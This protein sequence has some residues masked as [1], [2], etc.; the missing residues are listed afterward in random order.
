MVAPRINLKKSTSKLVIIFSSVVFSSLLALTPLIQNIEENFGLSLLFHM[1]GEISAPEDTI[2]IAMDRASAKDLQIPDQRGIWPRQYHT[3][4]TQQLNEAGA[5]VIVFDILFK[6]KYSKTIDYNFAQAI[7]TADNVVLFE[8]LDREIAD[9]QASNIII[10]KQ[11]RPIKILDQSAAA[12]AAFPLPKVP[13]K[14]SQYWK[15]TPSTGGSPSLPSSALLI[16]LIDYLPTF[17]EQQ[18]HL[19]IATN[20]KISFSTKDIQK[21]LTGKPT[22]PFAI[23]NNSQEISA[24]NSLYNSKNSEYLNFYG[25]AQTIKTISYSKV[26]RMSPEQ[27]HRIFHNKAVFI[28]A[29]N[30]QQ[31]N[32]HDSFHTIFTDEDGLDISGVE[33]AATAFSNL[34][35]SKP[36]TPLT[37]TNTLSVIALWGAVISLLCISLPALFSLL[38]IIFLSTIYLSLSITI[39]TSYNLW[40]PIIMPLLIQTILIF[41]TSITYRNVLAGKER[42]KIIKT[43]TRFIPEQEIEQL[44]KTTTSQHNKGKIV[45]GI[46]LFTDIEQYTS[47]SETLSPNELSQLINQY[48][49]KVFAIIQ[50]YDGFISDAKGDS[51]LAIWSA[52]K[53]NIK[54]YSSACHAALDISSAINKFNTHNFKSPLPTRIGL[55][56]GEFHLG[57]SGTNEHYE[58]RTTGDCINTCARVTGMNK[59]LGTKILITEELLAHVDDVT[60][61]PLGRFKL[62]GKEKNINLA[63][64][65]SKK[66]HHQSKNILTLESFSKGLDFFTNQQW[67]EA[68]KQFSSS[69]NHDLAANFYIQ[70]CEQLQQTNLPEDWDGSITMNEK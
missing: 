34:L 57:I 54:A 35:E 20:D 12:T 23:K 70:H 43:F 3:R 67:N 4:L 26:L 18:S 22:N 64:L 52:D 2:I 21:E 8:Y 17:I 38:S 59:H 33:I 42:K 14:V 10:N 39:F 27:R 1:R 16:Y 5:K 28:G 65:I 61:R 53:N 31:W 44:L 13:F 11:I 29:S 36:I 50:Q 15:F 58:Y 63:E 32:Q 19:S 40:P 56:C 9:S 41:L 45:S 48:H 62:A 6:K 66:T 55:H 7:K 25:K 46:A 60:T 37:L 69:A 49:Q 24:L 68:K 47:L 30:N 51:V